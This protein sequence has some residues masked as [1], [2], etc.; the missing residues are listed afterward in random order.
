MAPAARAAA[1]AAQKK[2]AAQSPAQPSGTL[3]DRKLSHGM[4]RT[5]VARHTSPP[6]TSIWPFA[7]V[8]L[9]AVLFAIWNGHSVKS[10]HWTP[11]SSTPSNSRTDDD[12][13]DASCAADV[14]A[15]RCQADAA[16]ARAAPIVRR[17]AARR[18]VRRVEA[19]R[20]LRPRVPFAR[21]L[22]RHVRDRVACRRRAPGD[23]LPDCA[24]RAARGECRRQ[25]RYFLSQCFLSCGRAGPVPFAALLDGRG[26]CA[27]PVGRRAPRA[28][29]AGRRRDAG[30]RRRQPAVEVEW[31]HESPR[32]RGAAS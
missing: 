2:A 7:L 22:R 30:R 10:T 23:E 14:A 28:A 31:L 24:A 32:P 8:A 18:Q 21:A 11:S 3:S 9:A 4:A 26:H 29:R 20:P 6:P 5:T 13:D 17:R 1:I 12:A 15:G 27:L 25:R 19:A 16:V